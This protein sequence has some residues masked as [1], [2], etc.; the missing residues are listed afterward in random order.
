MW[1]CLLWSHIATA[2][3]AANVLYSFVIC[4]SLYTAK[5]QLS[6]LKKNNFFYFRRKKIVI[7]DL[8]YTAIVIQKTFVLLV[9][10]AVKLNREYEN[11]I[12]CIEE[13]KFFLF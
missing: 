6:I 12:E 4:D 9:R 3:K 7:C 8:L 2:T 1:L 5:I 11:S 10:V 13:K